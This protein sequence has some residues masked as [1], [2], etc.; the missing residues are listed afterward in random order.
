MSK[1]IHVNFSR[2]TNCRAC[3]VACQMENQGRSFVHVHLV[4]DLFAA[5]LLCR[6]CDPA[7]CALSCPTRALDP[8]DGD[9]K[10]HPEK[11]SGCGLCLGACPFGMIGYNAKDNVAA[12]CNLCAPRLARGL[13][14]AC[15][16]ACP[17]AALSYRDF[18][19]HA[20]NER[21]R[22]SARMGGMGG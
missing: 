12:L 10:L 21:R 20:A 1:Q 8:E 3:E 14:P 9:L 17:T 7:P 6:R 15:V 16:L 5:P 13:E 2:C 19:D 4:N 22:V 18:D 11:C